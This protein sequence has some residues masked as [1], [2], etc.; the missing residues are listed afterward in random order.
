MALQ[1]KLVQEVDIERVA[2]V[3]DCLAHL[4]LER[5][6]RRLARVEAAED[7]VLVLEEQVE[8]VD[9]LGARLVDVRLLVD[10]HL[11]RPPFLDYGFQILELRGRY[12]GL[13]D[14]GLRAVRLVGMEREVRLQVILAAKG[15]AAGRLPAVDKHMVGVVFPAELAS[16]QEHSFMHCPLRTRSNAYACALC[17]HMSIC[18]SPRDT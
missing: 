3:L 9:S 17:A 1:K 2:P 8:P 6:R 16:A 12:R 13:L 4:C 10:D 11:L 15:L 14:A 18:M 7:V 5:S